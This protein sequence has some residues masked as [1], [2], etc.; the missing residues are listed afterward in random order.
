MADPPAER[1]KSVP[2]FS[3][4]G[5]DVFGPWEVTTHLSTRGGQANSKI[6]AVLF[7]CMSKRAIHIEII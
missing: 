7:S 5:L 2:P 4:V 6:W 1:L 3:Y